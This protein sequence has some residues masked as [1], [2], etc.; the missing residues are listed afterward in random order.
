MMNVKPLVILLAEDNQDH[1]EMIIETLEEFNVRN[2]IFHVTNG[3]LALNFLNKEPPYDS[4]DC[5]RPDL[6]LLDQKMPLLDGVSTLKAIRENADFK[7]IPVIM[8]STST[9][10]AEIGQCFELGANSYVTKPLNFEE[11]ARKIRDLNLYWVLT[12]ELP[13]QSNPQK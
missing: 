4:Q 5:P 2:Q 3:E 13:D 8:V 11:F 9:A 6:I 12:S 7:H 1:A 10:G